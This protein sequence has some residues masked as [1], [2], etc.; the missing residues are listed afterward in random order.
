[1]GPAACGLKDERRCHNLQLLDCQILPQETPEDQEEPLSEALAPMTL[2][3]VREAGICLLWLACF[4]PSLSIFSAVS[5]LLFPVSIV[6]FFF[7]FLLGFYFPIMLLSWA[8]YLLKFRFIL[9]F[10]C[11]LL[12]Y[13]VSSKLFCICFHLLFY[14]IVGFY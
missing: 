7:F 2:H 6:V 1:M 11:I 10:C 8:I 14:G 4:T 12:F 13:S 5:V 3:F 9:L